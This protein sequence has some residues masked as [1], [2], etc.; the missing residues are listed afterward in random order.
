MN[1]LKKTISLLLAMLLAFSCFAVTASAEEDEDYFRC[2]ENVTWSY[3][4][5]TNTILIEGTGPMYDYGNGTSEDDKWSPWVFD[6]VHIDGETYTPERIVIGEGITYVGN[7]T[8][9]DQIVKQLEL[10]E[11]LTGIGEYAF[12]RCY[13]LVSIHIPSGVTDLDPSAFVYCSSLKSV[14][15][16]EDNPAYATDGSGVIYTKDLST[17]VAC[18]IDKTGETFVI[19]EGVTTIG[20][21]AFFAT[22]LGGIVIP[23]SVTRIEDR[24]FLWCSVPSIHIPESVTYIGS[25]GVAGGYQMKTITVDENSGYFVTDEHGVLYDKNM[26]RVIQCPQ[27]NPL[28]SYV[29]PDTVKVICDGAFSNCDSLQSVTL[30]EGLTTI[31]DE[32]FLA[33]NSLSSI[34][35]P[36]SLTTVGEWAFGGCAMTSVTIP[37]GIK[38][39]EPYA[40]SCDYLTNV[41]ICEGV[42]EIKE[43]AFSSLYYLQ[44]LTIPKSV[45]KIGAD[46]FEGCD[47]LLWVNYGG[48]AADAKKIDIADGNDKVEKLMG[49]ET[50]FERIGNFFGAV[51]D[52]IGNFFEDIAWHLAA[53]A[54]WIMGLFA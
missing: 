18:F 4:E 34:N 30:P 23:D 1:T 12:E 29:V 17:V 11:S 38:V 40:F 41:V 15:V 31:E 39:I 10:P 54:E 22:T 21:G 13:D 28:T 48:T 27:T 8:F 33:S 16:S 32:A 36:E 37:G 24:A 20:E 6:N 43:E 26:T 50:V 2:G 25:E 9:R 35:L 49:G 5:A 46:A 19:P 3:E 7:N 53:F 14:T 45:T 52:R 47:N 44:S 51:I 42:T